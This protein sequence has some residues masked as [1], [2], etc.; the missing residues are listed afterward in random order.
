MTPSEATRRR[1][2]DLFDGSGVNIQKIE[3]MSGELEVLGLRACDILVDDLLRYGNQITDKHASALARIID[4]Y[5]TLA[6]RLESGRWVYDLDTGIVTLT[7]NVR[8][9]K[10]DSR[11]NGE[12]AEINLNTGVSKLLAEKR[13]R[14][15]MLLNQS[16]Q[17]C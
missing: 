1:L 8:L 17:D 10:C 13:G 7:G 6:T 15:R 16:K 9:T 2:C 14:V 3:S 5:S 12:K 4:R 11:L